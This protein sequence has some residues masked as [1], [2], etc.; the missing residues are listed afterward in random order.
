MGRNH[1]LRDLA[2]AL[3]NQRH[4]THS[5]PVPVSIGGY[6]GLYIKATAPANLHP[7]EFTSVDEP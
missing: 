1:L 3:V 6:R 5:R 7:A 2:T 4:M